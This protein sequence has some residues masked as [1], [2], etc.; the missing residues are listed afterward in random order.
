MVD[1]P[2][3]ERVFFGV[4]LAFEGTDRSYFLFYFLV[5]RWKETVR[6][7]KENKTKALVILV[8]FSL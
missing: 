4:A 2:M 1:G 3:L 6:K 8:G 7:Q 5:Q